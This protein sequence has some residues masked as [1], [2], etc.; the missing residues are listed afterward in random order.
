MMLAHAYQHRFHIQPLLV[1]TQTMNLWKIFLRKLGYKQANRKF[2]FDQRTI[3]SLRSL[4]EREQRPEQELAADLLSYALVQRE[5][6]DRYM[7]CWQSLSARE[8]EIAA[9]VCMGN[10]NPEIA[11]TLKISPETVKSHIR[12]IV[13]KF[14]LRT[15]A[16]LRQVL[17]RWDFTAWK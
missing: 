11:N 9:L 15:K 17:I 1:P 5:V 2:E 7:E 8:Q 4:A 12:H 10:T 16:E 3:Q 14:G 13:H 6:T